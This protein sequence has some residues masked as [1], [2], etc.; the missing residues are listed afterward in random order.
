LNSATDTTP[1]MVVF[2]WNARVT[3]VF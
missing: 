2:C 1:K 3:R